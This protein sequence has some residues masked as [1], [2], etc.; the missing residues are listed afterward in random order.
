MRRSHWHVQC[1]GD[2]FAFIVHTRLVERST[3]QE[4][5]RGEVW[6]GGSVISVVVFQLHLVVN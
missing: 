1:S 3:T 5:R 2:F 4:A 6:I